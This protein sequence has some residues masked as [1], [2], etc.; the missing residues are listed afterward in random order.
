MTDIIG[1]CYRTRCESFIASNCSR[2][3]LSWFC[4]RRKMSKAVAAPVRE[5]EKN[6]FV[7]NPLAVPFYGPV[8]RGL[9]QRILSFQVRAAMRRLGFQR[10][11]NW[12]FNP[13]AASVA[14]HLSE[15]LIIYYCVDEYT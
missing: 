4:Q 12:V 15:D 6:I 3:R 9:N 8:G 2:A 1:N 10:P 5:V 14:G 11:I 7:L 13:A